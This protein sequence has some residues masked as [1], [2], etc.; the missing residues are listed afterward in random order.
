M[1]HVR[2]W[3]IPSHRAAEALSLLETLQSSAPVGLGFVDRE[4]RILH[5]NEMLAAVNGSDVE[6]QIGKRVAEV[7]PEIWPRIEGVYRRVMEDDEAI[8]NTEV[9]GEIA[10]EPGRQHIGWRA[11]TRSISTARSSA[12]AWSWSTSPSVARPRSSG[13][14]P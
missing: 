4:F 5:I 12:R 2:I 1:E 11:T 14:S 6:D 13:R 10:A 9:F 7:V 3:P 8:L